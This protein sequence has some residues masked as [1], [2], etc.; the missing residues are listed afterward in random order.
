[1]VVLTI[2]IFILVSIASFSPND[3]P[4]ANY[5]V[6]KSVQNYCG[7]I[8]AGIS[9]YLISGIGVT[10]YILALL[11][12]ALG[13]VLILRRKVEVLWVRI[14]GGILLIVSVAPILGLFSSVVTGV[15]RLPTEAS[16][17]IGMIAAA[18][19]TEYLGI[20][21]TCILLSL[22]FL[23]SI[24]LIS[25]I[26]L[27]VPLNWAIKKIKEVF[28]VRPLASDNVEDTHDYSLSSRDWDLVEETDAPEKPAEETEEN[29]TATDVLLPD[30][31][32]KSK[33]KITVFKKNVLPYI[34]LPYM[35]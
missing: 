29:V 24:M 26:S 3:P 9:G 31:E 19:L 6:N 25:N 2:A 5:P 28:V 12:G 18:R 35:L 20:P 21:G 4:F 10:S 7:K 32:T 1:M 34:P 30:T 33:K 27:E 8:G 11:I 22:G 16:G 15:F 17:I 23:V 14:L 13:F